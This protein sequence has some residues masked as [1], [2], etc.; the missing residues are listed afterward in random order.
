MRQHADAAGGGGH[1]VDLGGRNTVDESAAFRGGSP[2]HPRA[3]G[4]V[5]GHPVPTPSPLGVSRR[6]EPFGAP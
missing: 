6:P 5:T 2:E 4:A 3:S 1:K